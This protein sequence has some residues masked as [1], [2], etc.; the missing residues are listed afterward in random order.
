MKKINFLLV[1][2]LSCLGYIKAQDGLENIIVET[3]YVAGAADGLP[4]GTKTYRVYADLAPGWAL[5]TFYG[6]TA[7]PLRIY[8]ST[9]F[10]NTYANKSLAT[11][12]D[13]T[14][15]TGLR[16]L[17]SWLTLGAGADTYNGVLKSEDDGVDN[18]LTTSSLLNNVTTEMGIGLKTQDGYIA[19]DGVGTD[20][21]ASIS[22]NG[23]TN[24]LAAVFYS[25]S[26]VANNF[27]S[28]NF[29]LGVPSFT[30][31]TAANRV[32]LGQFTTAGTFG[33]E[34]NVQ[35]RNTTTLA[36][37]NF[38]HSNPTGAERTIPSLTLTPM[39]VAI[40]TPTT[41]SVYTAG[42]A[43]MATATS[44]VAGLDSIVFVYNGIKSVDV[45]AAGGYTASFSAN[46]AA[47]SMTAT[48]WKNGSNAS[49]SVTFTVNAD[50]VNPTVTTFTTTPA[51]S[52]IAGT[53]VT[54]NASATDNGTVVSAQFKDGS[55]NIGALQTG[56]GPF[57]VNWTAVAPNGAHTLSVVVTD[58]AGNQT[59]S[60]LTFTVLGDPAATVTSFTTTPAT[61]AVAG[62]SVTLNATATDNG[63]VTGATFFDGATA[64]GAPIVGA[65][66]F[67]TAWTA[68]GAGAHTLSVVV[69]DNSGNSTTSTLTFTVL[70]DP[71][72]TVTVFTAT[73]GTVYVTETVT[74]NATADDVLTT[75]PAAGSIVSAQF[76]DGTT[77]IGA[78]IP[79]AGPF[80][81]TW[82][83]TGAS[84]HTL[85]VVVTDNGGTT[86]ERTAT[87]V[88]NAD[89]A[90]VITSF[91][92]TPS[93]PQLV[94]TPVVLAATATDAFGTSLSAQFKVNGINE[95][96]PVTSSPYQTTWTPATRGSYTISVVFTDNAGNTATQATLFEVTSSQKYEVRQDTAL[97]NEENICVPIQTLQAVSNIIGFDL[98]MGYDE[99]KVIP[100][101]V[102]RKGGVL[103]PNN[104]VETAYK[105]VNTPSTT[106]KMLISVFF[107]SNADINQRF[108]GPANVDL[109]CVEFAKKPA[110][111]PTSA[112]RF[113]VDTFEESYITGVVPERVGANNFVTYKD[114][115]FHS[116]LE[117][118]FDGSPLSNVSATNPTNIYG[119]NASCAKALNPVQPDVNGEFTHYLN[120]NELYLNIERDIAGSTGVPSATDADVQPVINGFDALLVRRVLLDDASFVPSI[121]QMIAMDVNMDGQVSAGDASQINQRSIKKIGEFRQAWNYNNAGVSNGQLS[122]DWLFINELAIFNNPNGQYSVSATYPRWDNAGYNKDHVPVTSFCSPVPVSDWTRCSVISEDSYIGVLLGDVNGNYANL[123]AGVTAPNLRSSNRIVVDLAK[124]VVNGNTVDV[125]VSIVSSDDVNALD[126][127]ILST[128]NVTFNTAIANTADAQ[129]ASFLNTND[130]TARFTS[131]S[132]VAYDLTKKVATVRFTLNNGTINASDLLSVEGYINGEKAAVEIRDAKSADASLVDVNIYP[133]PATSVI[134]VIATQDATAELFDITGKKVLLSTKV[135][136][137]QNAQI[138]VESINTGVYMMKVSNDNF[139]NTKKVFISK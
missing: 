53:S 117:F 15:L 119:A 116:N 132:V 62:T 34:I 95:G 9:N 29:A 49:A 4:A 51:T 73:P 128:E 89:P 108:A 109:I 37:Q 20:A 122:K 75:T 63:T 17:D 71:A 102:I 98:E 45:D 123:V 70:A 74:L 138:D 66:P 103:A 26:S 57:T 77:P 25:G 68:T 3:Y 78:A 31:T 76:F 87:V 18:I 99:T 94:G 133:N 21:I 69:T 101:G 56:A 110:F 43:I 114:S 6:N 96:A 54:L 12:I 79:G 8:S 84:T 40:T 107:N 97:C 112:V 44:T 14:A 120:D 7:H 139:V 113:T 35:V 118:W 58:N 86:A 1:M 13:A 28:S 121:Y 93:S 105:I 10:Q 48:A 59:T 24:T 134:N 64:I 50:L 127:A 30:G 111:L 32:L 90:P 85:K 61:S 60:T 125:P 126:M 47:N 91:T 135:T 52:A 137:N 11:A 100:T 130:A 38:V 104:L 27:T 39:D 80:T 16:G 124:A 72:P 41:A 106:G 36:V 46:A 131:N 19:D 23:Y 129:V 42:D 88:V 136:A 67:T 65:G 83:A 5:Q 82:T 2:F 92:A 81:R 115:T 22:T 55:T 33:F